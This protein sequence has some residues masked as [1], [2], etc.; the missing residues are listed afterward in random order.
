MLKAHD[1]TMFYKS[2]CLIFLITL[3]VVGS[4]GSGGNVGSLQGYAGVVLGKWDSSW[5]PITGNRGNLIM[6]K[7]E[8][9]AIISIRLENCMQG[10]SVFQDQF[11]WELLIYLCAH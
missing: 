1:S 10:D 6:I 2:F 3:Q 9:M 8:Q 5:S 11:V 7:L 4:L